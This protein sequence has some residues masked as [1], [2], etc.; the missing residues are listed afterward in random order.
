M[1]AQSDL[2]FVLENNECTRV[3]LHRFLSAIGWQV[4]SFGSS[5]DCFQAV[6]QQVPACILA[7][8]YPAG[9]NA[10]E[11]QKALRSGDVVCPMVI[12]TSNADTSL[13]S[14]ARAVGIYDVLDKSCDL[15]KLESTLQLA[16]Q[17]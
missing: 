12:V 9:M 16:A 2:L 17:G 7:D 4:R 14:A 11:L 5:Y 3:A 6:L 8:L 1:P 15:Q 13:V 10:I